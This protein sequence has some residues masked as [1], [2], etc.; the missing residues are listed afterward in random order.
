METFG[1][2]PDAADLI[3]HAAWLKRLA[4]ALVGDVATADD[5]VQETFVTALSRPPRG[6]RMPR[7]WL[8]R[9][10]RNAAKQTFRSRGRRTQREAETAGPVPLP[11]PRETV[12]RLDTERCLTEELA[13]LDEPFRTTLMLRYYDGL[14][15]AEIAARTSTP[16][17]TVR[18]RLQRGLELLRERL[19]GRFGQRAAWCALFLPI[20]RSQPLAVTTA[21]TSVLPGILLMSTFWKVAAVAG[22]A[23]AIA[24]GLMVAGV[25]PGSTPTLTGDTPLEVAFRPI[26]AHA[27]TL[28]REILELPED[29][30]RSAIP[31]A[32]AE[33]APAPSASP[34]RVEAR[35]VDTAGVP[36]SGVELRRL[37]APGPT[38]RSAKDGHVA[39]SLELGERP[40]AIALEF[41][42][43]GYA[44]RGEK[45]V[46]AAG[47]AVHLGTLV[48]EPGGAVSGRV[49]DASG[50][51]IDNAR[52][53]FEP[54]TESSRALEARRIPGGFTSVPMTR[55][56]ANGRFDLVGLRA[57]FVRVCA[58]AP[59]FLAGFTPPVGV[60]AGQEAYD[61]ELRL[62]PLPPAN[63]LRGI[64]LD[65]S[66]APVPHAWLEFRNESRSTGN[67]SSGSRT[68]DAQGR[69][70]FRLL[71]DARTW[72][73]ARDP[74]G[75]YA[76][77]ALNDLP[78]GGP[79]VV[80]QL[81]EAPRIALVVN[82]A[83]GQSIEEYAFEVLG[84]DKLT[85]HERALRAP[86]PHG[87]ADFK[88]PASE[89]IVSID[90][91]GHE[92]AI[93]GPFDP[94][95]V[96]ATLTARLVPV[97]GLHG[98]VLL[99]GGT[100]PAVGAK[101]TLHELAPVDAEYLVNGFHSRF[102]G[103]AVNE[104][105][106]D[107]DGAFLLTVRH[108]GAYVVRAERSGHAPAESPV[109]GVGP[110]LHAEDVELALGPGGTIEGRV[111]R[112]DGTDAAGTILGLSRG[113]GFGRTLRVGPEGTF[114]I[115]H[116]TPGPWWIDVRSEELD[117]GTTTTLDRGRRREGP[118][119]P[120][121]HVVEG[122]TTWHE[123]EIDA[124]PACVLEGCLR[125]D[126][127]PAKA[128]Q[129]R[130]VPHEMVI[131]Q[132]ESEGKPFDIGGCFRIDAKKAGTYW[133]VLTG[134]FE[135]YGDQVLVDVIELAPGVARWEKSIRTG[136]L[137][138]DGAAEWSGK[139][140]PVSAYYWEGGGKL[141]GLTIIAA[142]K[143]GVARVP[144][145]PAGKG[146][147]VRPDATNF[148]FAK[149]PTLIELEVPSGG[150]VRVRLP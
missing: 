15:P 86:R 146:R 20:T 147:I 71:D 65:P 83:E 75:L 85:L 4:V 102:Q 94:V 98:R 62:E 130:L 51:G 16:G 139:D 69:F 61:V 24:I 97:P 31:G 127:E 96:A 107:A 60:R 80:L 2:H 39:L 125:V 44:S 92:R 63:R 148:D 108:P 76:T 149:W 18:W 118:G 17:G 45:P 46:L 103:G 82:G 58:E 23:I 48:L 6:G 67:T 129:V 81:A 35:V 1:E 132:D 115:E 100:A 106:C 14:T 8:E 110:D 11:G 140:V 117:P 68:A 78:T 145:V 136:A 101:V 34:A 74:A 41:R 5:L 114:R 13:R 126:G 112:T 142:N 26:S 32:A 150:E 93:L 28:A 99:A 133:L 43:P 131:F 52:V 122:Q 105:V 47:G 144:S 137:V 55:T 56:D 29:S 7:A 42:S 95:S 9:V 141:F 124:A 135:Q 37:D 70:E 73:T 33:I 19:D 40:R 123:F 10:V 3:R 25:L 91:P 64:V 59:G 72:L 90:A 38:A 116:L 84:P 89:F 134:A 113:D 120:T 22:C 79:D 119:D 138:V 21:S 53:A 27:Y 12:E 121:C 36:L 111:R 54:A 50:K 128:W 49:L 104:A 66:G 57:G 87:T 30:A 77:T 143:E 88:R 109:V